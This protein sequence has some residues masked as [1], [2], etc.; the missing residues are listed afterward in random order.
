MS[1][2]ICNHCGSRLDANDNYCPKCG[3]QYQ[4]T[5]NTPQPTEVEYQVEQ[6]RKIKDGYQALSD[7]RADFLEVFFLRLS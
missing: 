6:E 7:L 1:F 4:A 5:T 3:T 2:K